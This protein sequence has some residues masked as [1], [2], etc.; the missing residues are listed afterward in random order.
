MLEA[1]YIKRYSI[2]ARICLAI[3]IAGGTLLLVAVPFNLLL[4]H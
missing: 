4:A 1:P 3:A 2:A